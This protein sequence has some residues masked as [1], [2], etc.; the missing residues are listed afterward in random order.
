M[1]IYSQRHMLYSN[2]FKL[3]LALEQPSY[4]S[5]SPEGVMLAVDRSKTRVSVIRDGSV[6]GIASGGKETEGF[7]YAECAVTDGEKI[8]IAD[9]RYDSVSTSIAAERVIQ[10]SANGRY[11]KILFERLYGDV[12]NKPMQ[13]GNIR[14]LQYYGGSLFFVLKGAASLDLH[15]ISDGQASIVRS[16]FYGALSY[17]DSRHVLYD[18]PRDAIYVMNLRCEL[19]SESGGKMR[20]AYDWSGN[21]RGQIPWEIAAGSDGRLF[22]TDLAISGVVSLPEYAEVFKT[23]SI[24]HGMTVN[25]K[26]VIS[27]A[28][29]GGV[30]QTTSDGVLLYSGDVFP[31]SKGFLL[32]RFVVWGLLLAVFAEASYLVIRLAARAA[33]EKSGVRV[34]LMLA[35][36]ISIAITSSLVCAGILRSENERMSEARRQSL[37]QL[38][39]TMSKISPDTYGDSLE[40]I[41]SL[42]DHGGG[43][44]NR[45]RS[46]LAPPCDSAARE[47]AYMYYAVMKFSWEDDA[48][49]G[50]MDYENTIPTVYPIGEFAGSGYDEIAH[51]DVPYM[52]RSESDVYGSWTFVAAPA[53]NSAGDVV[54]LIEFGYN[55]FSDRLAKAAQI[56][57]T[58][59]GAAVLVIIFLL[60]SSEIVAVSGCGW[61]FPRLRADPGDSMPEFIRPVTFIAFLADNVSAAFIAQLSARVYESSSVALPIS[62][63]M[64]SALPLSV[65]LFSVALSFAVAGRLI[66]RL[67]QRRVLCGGILAQSAGLAVIS[68]AVASG[69]YGM[70]LAGEA[71]TGVGLSLSTVVTNAVPMRFQDENRRNSLLGSVNTG[72]M[73]GV[74]VGAS[75]GPYI[76][77]VCGYPFTF[78]CASAL[79]LSAL[80]FGYACIPGDAPAMAAS[81]DSRSISTG[82]FLADRHVCK[83]FLLLMLPFN[84]ILGFKDYLFPLYVNGLGYS[85]VTIGQVLLFSGAVAIFAGAPLAGYM[86]ERIGAKY[87]NVAVNFTC[88]FGII[89]F[90]VIPSF[91]S[92]VTAACV[93][94]ILDG[95][96]MVI[97]NIYFATLGAVIAYGGNRS[98][99]IY[100]LASSLSLASGP[101]LL[102]ALLEMGHGNACLLVGGAGTIFLLVFIMFCVIE[103]RFARTEG[104]ERV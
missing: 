16:V 31:L 75:I 96:G 65:K 39:Q 100:N 74:V 22:A 52:Y 61:D 93:I 53:Y 33:S 15:R 45:V 18:A 47:G 91:A 77:E 24:P 35:V 73:S 101:V 51:G 82:Q 44:F 43:A 66:G 3:A 36:G 21:G 17:A 84:V 71:V 11:E 69:N 41:T 86:R 98:M 70:L 89:I 48:L 94:N 76:A 30:Y 97:Q 88:I 34:R 72:I 10:Y 87:G 13:Y 46:F 6:R 49:Y 42:R 25:E 5:T 38:A 1:I 104:E 19:Y 9:V 7:Y 14:S 2:P 28:D 56:R 95:F 64:S 80:F 12:R 23:K 60:L 27:V 37:V 102:G 58:A 55:L 67:G 32:G 90:G 59:L 4:V 40:S 103:N 50:V 99:G 63:A 68:A 26:D 79:T 78:G 54:G 8:Y 85:D 92:S 57:E 20:S 81:A 83:F 29:A 62:G